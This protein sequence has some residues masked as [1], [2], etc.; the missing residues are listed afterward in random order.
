[1]KEEDNKYTFR[2]FSVNGNKRT[3]Y[4][5]HINCLFAI[6]REFLKELLEYKNQCTIYLGYA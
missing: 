3:K 6:V 1:M 2:G 5:M 4:I